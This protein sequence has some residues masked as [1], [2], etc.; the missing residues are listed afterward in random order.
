MNT[1]K[2]AIHHG[3]INRRNARANL[4]TRGA[5]SSGLLAVCAIAA[6]LLP[7]GSGCAS[8]GTDSPDDDSVEAE[9]AALVSAPTALALNNQTSVFDLG[10][11]VEKDFA[12]SSIPG[13]GRTVVVELQPATG[14]TDLYVGWSTSLSRSNFQCASTSGGTTTDRCYV[15]VPNDGV[16][17]TLYIKSYGYVGG[18]AWLHAGSLPLNGLDVNGGART[19]TLPA[20]NLWYYYQFTLPPNVARAVVR[21]TTLS[22]SDLSMIVNSCYSGAAGAVH[23]CQVEG[24]GQWQTVTG[25]FKSASGAT[26]NV[27]VDG[28]DRLFSFA[29][30]G[31]NADTASINSIVDHQLLSWYSKDNQA[32]DSWG[33]IGMKPNGSWLDCYKQV[34][35]GDFTANGSYKGAGHPDTLC[36]DGHPGFDFKASTGT[37]ILAA[38]AGTVHVPAKDAVNGNP[39]NFNTFYLD[40]GGGWTAWMLHASTHIPDGS[41]VAAGAFVGKVGSTGTGAPHL[42]LEIRRNDVPVDPYGWSGTAI[43]P[44]WIVPAVRLWQ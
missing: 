29:L 24:T 13:D 9:S 41:S 32:V 26:L 15:T 30:P 18:R 38:C 27:E 8:A 3:T 37:D 23:S 22:G 31:Q 44:M 1:T 4:R 33:E 40:C 6:M 14:D 17:R 20:D 16:L 21:S 36:Y 12:V 10:T 34:G 11:G 42:H 7:L 39:S 43:D 5:T 35:G 28:T 19:F 2:L 25:Y